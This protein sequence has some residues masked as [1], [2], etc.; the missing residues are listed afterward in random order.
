MGAHACTTAVIEFLTARTPGM[1]CTLRG[2]D[3]ELVLIDGTVAEHDRLG[4][5]RGD[6]SAKHRRYGSHAPSAT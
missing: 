4:D 1:W 3:P 2:A 6:Y 5:G